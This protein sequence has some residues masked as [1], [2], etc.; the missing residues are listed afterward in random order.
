MATELG[1]HLYFEDV[2]PGL[3]LPPLQ[4]PPLTTTQLVLYCGAAGVFD[5]IHFDIDAAR[6]AGFPE[7]VVNGSLRVAFL[8]QLL[9][10]WMGADGFVRKLTCRHRGLVLRGD[11]VTSRGRVVRTIVE[12]EAGLAELEVWN[13][14]ERSGRTDLGTAVVTLPRRLTGGA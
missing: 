5:P 9:T 13:E 7:L 12:A 10:R 4:R 6:A 3:E 1:R 8:A 14:T 2:I 11:V